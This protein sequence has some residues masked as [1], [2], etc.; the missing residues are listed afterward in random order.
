MKITITHKE[1]SLVLEECTVITAATASLIDL[2]LQKTIPSTQEPL[3]PDFESPVK[4]DDTNDKSIED[5][6]KKLELEKAYKKANPYPPKEVL[7]PWTV[8]PTIK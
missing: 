4:K 3:L 1:T 2:F 6:L 5:M 7:T 8:T